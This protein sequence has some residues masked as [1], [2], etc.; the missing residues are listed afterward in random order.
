M[1]TQ[2][3][4][5]LVAQKPESR[6]RSTSAGSTSQDDIDDGYMRTSLRSHQARASL[7]PEYDYPTPFIVKNT[8]IDTPIFRPMSLDEFLHERRVH[9]CPVEVQPDLLSDM[10][11]EEIAPQVLQR[12][13]TTNAAV[14]FVT[15]ASDAAAAAAD[16]AA[17]VR[18]WWT[19]QEWP[20]LQS[21]DESVGWPALPS[22]A[23]ETGHRWPALPSSAREGVAQGWPAVRSSD[24]EVDM[25]AHPQVLSLA[26]AIVNPQLGTV[27]MPTV[28]SLGHH[29]GSCKPCAFF[30][31]QGCGNGVQCPFCHLCDQNEKKRRQKDKVAKIKEMRRAY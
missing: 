31:K 7:V 26:D 14:A 28:G 24:G 20:V 29:M 21:S 22:S 30:H 27:D 12:A 17:R 25:V 13:A 2:F 19:P 3:S 11:E 18:S 15:A 1:Q 5:M 6:S 23:G 9:S 16:A 10:E 4:T 8:F